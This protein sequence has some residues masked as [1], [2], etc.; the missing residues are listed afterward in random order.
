M[1]KVMRA[2]CIQTLSFGPY[3]CVA[4][5]GDFVKYKRNERLFCVLCKEERY[6]TWWIPLSR[7]EFE[8]CFRE[9]HRTGDACSLELY[10]PE[11]VAS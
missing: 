1:W 8:A 9:I 11:S 5:E 2:E 6:R 7:W 3:L 4:K 10:S